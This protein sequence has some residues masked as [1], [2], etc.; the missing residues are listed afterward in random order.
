MIDH[1]SSAKAG[2]ERASDKL[3]SVIA[4]NADFMS[5]PDFGKS[6]RRVGMLR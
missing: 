2:A 5:H 3:A 6:G 4:A 1:L